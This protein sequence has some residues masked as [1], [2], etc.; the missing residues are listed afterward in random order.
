MLKMA[1]ILVQNELFLFLLTKETRNNH[2][3]ERN[4]LQQVFWLI[5]GGNDL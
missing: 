4:F 2:V 1:T 5:L 3:I